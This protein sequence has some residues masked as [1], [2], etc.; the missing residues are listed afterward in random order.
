MPNI[1][2][3]KDEIKVMADLKDI[4]NMLEQIAA[5]DIAQMRSRIV[6]SRPYFQEIWKIH[7]ILKQIVPPPSNILHKHLVVLVALDWG[8]PGGLLNQ[9][10]NTAEEQY[11]KYEADLMVTGKMG[12]KRFMGRDERTMHLFNVPKT[13]TLDDIEPIYKVVANYAHVHIV[14]P[15]FVSL[16]KQ[17][18]SIANFSVD[19]VMYEQDEIKAKRFLTEPSPQEV[20]DFINETII[21][22]T[23]YH[24]FSEAQLAYSA[25]QMVAMRNAY[26]NAKDESESLTQLY[27]RAKREIIDT[28]L[29]ELYGATVTTT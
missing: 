27:H 11:K 3:L 14:Y 6:G 16:S 26:D 25:A 8:M 22:A 28:K 13:S 10:V 18:V 29:R 21:G 4:T 1:D 20:S 7:A 24:Y 19:D 12:H 23:L 5:R 17:E 2:G 15:R 9:V